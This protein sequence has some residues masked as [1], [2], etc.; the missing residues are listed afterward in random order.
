MNKMDVVSKRIKAAVKLG[1]YSLARFFADAVASAD[2]LIK[3]I[4]KSLTEVNAV[5]EQVEKDISK[6]LTD[7]AVSSDAP[8][9]EP[10]KVLTDGASSTDAAVLL[11][12]KGLS[13]TNGASDVFFRQADYVRAFTESPLSEDVYVAALS[14]PLS[15]DT[16]V[17]EIVLKL[18]TLAKADTTLIADAGFLLN[19]DYVDNAGYFLEDY[20]GD[21][22]TF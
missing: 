19:Q 10:G 8:S 22:R 14:K 5:S 11:A 17:S 1:V 9:L 15:D 12:T 3:S 18:S 2:I 16:V 4:T 21:K 6:P 20:V 7:D 13:D